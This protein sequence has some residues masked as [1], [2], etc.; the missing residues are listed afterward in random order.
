MMSNMDIGKDLQAAFDEGYAAKRLEVSNMK[1]MVY[2]E[3]GKRE[4]LAHGEDP[5]GYGYVI[6][7]LGTHPT[8]YVSLPKDDPYYEK[9]HTETSEAISRCVHGGLTYSNYDVRGDESYSPPNGWWL[10]WDYG[11]CDDYHGYYTGD[12]EENVWLRAHTKKWT[13][14]EI[15]DEVMAFIDKL[16]SH[17]KTCEERAKKI[18][19][20][21][22]LDNI[23]LALRTCADHNAV[24][25]KC[26]GECPYNGNYN[27]CVDQMI[28][29]A[30]DAIEKIQAKLDDA[31]KDKKKL[32]KKL[33][34]C[35]M[36]LD[37][38]RG[39]LRDPQNLYM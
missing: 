26:Y 30:A 16:D 11:H 10:G 34:Q 5:R 4:V 14:R 18:L 8:A 12:S 7:N 39:Y 31:E 15:Y 2:Q 25:D 23:V 17:R 27:E 13:T 21:E 20:S 24:G 32:R 3:D 28:L 38:V 36:D 9:G 35:E 6:L 29:D 19:T 37:R 33:K 1:P 22:G